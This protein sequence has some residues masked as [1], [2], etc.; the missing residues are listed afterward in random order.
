MR[1]GIC[2]LPEHRWSQAAPMWREA[3]AMGFD[4]AWTYDHL[5]WGGLRESPWYGTT[6]TLTAAATVTERIQLGTFVT[7]P[8]YRHPVTLMRDL[9]ALDDISDGRVIVGIGS[10]GE[11]DATILGGDPLTPREKVDRLDEFTD[12]LDRVLTRDHVDHEGRWFSCRDARTL[13]GPVPRDGQARMPF[14]LAANGPRAMGIA[15]RHGQG[16]VTTGDDTQ[17]EQ[18][19]Q[20]VARLCGRLDDVEAQ[21]DRARPLDRYLSLDSAEYRLTSLDAFTDAVG[22]AAELGFSDVVVHWPRPQAP[23]AGRR[24]VLDEVAAALPAL[25]GRA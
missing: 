1:F 15:V 20:G 4:H 6:P 2:I 14:V 11:P 22:R 10:G 12:L 23:Y 9:L 25:R 5:V 21:A 17:G 19:W 7:S 3:E 16:W 18:W 8:N 24:E 13:P